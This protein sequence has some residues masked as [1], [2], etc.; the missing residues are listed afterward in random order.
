MDEQTVEEI[1]VSKRNRMLTGG[2]GVVVFNNRDFFA[3]Y[4]SNSSKSLLPTS[5]SIWPTR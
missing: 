1:V 5:E 4:S 2:V 3:H